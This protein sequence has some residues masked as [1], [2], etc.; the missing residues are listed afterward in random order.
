MVV[1]ILAL[2]LALVAS[3]HLWTKGKPTREARQVYESLVHS[4]NTWALSD[5]SDD[6]LWHGDR[7]NRI[8]IS[9]YHRV[10]ATVS[11]VADPK[12]FMVDRSYIPGLGDEDS[13]FWPNA[14]Q[15]LV[16]PVAKKL[17]AKRRTEKRQDEDRLAHA[18]LENA[19][20]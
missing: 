9:L 6:V 19:L 17:L 20:Q 16:K 3:Y 10:T 11:G 8:E 1:I 5:Y 18:R 2:V 15:E 12:S 7:K 4:P 14:S 13:S